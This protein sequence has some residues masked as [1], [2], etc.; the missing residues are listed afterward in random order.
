MARRG[1]VAAGVVSCLVTASAN[2][3]VYFTFYTLNTPYTAT[4]PD[5]TQVMM[6]WSTNLTS[7]IVDQDDLTDWSISFLNGGNLFYTDNIVTAGS[8]QSLGGVTR[9][10]ADILFSFNLDTLTAGDFD[11]MLQGALLAGASGPAYNVYSY[12]TGPFDPPYSTLG[13][14]ANGNEATRELPGYSSVYTVPAPGVLAA[15]ALAGLSSRR[16]RA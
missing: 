13:I 7:G 6:S 9:G 3:G 15:L 14:W 16:R 2:A 12:P 4:S 1:A 5:V 10:I 8:V 11:N